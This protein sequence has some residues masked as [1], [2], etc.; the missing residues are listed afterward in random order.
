[1]SRII[2][3]IDII[4]GKCVR[5]EEGNY[6]RKKEYAANPLDMAKSYEDHGI[7]YLHLVDLDGAK[8]GQIINIQ[9]I[10]EICSQTNLI[11]D[12]GGG[13]KSDEDLKI[14]FE[15]G[16]KQVNIGSLAVKDP[17]LFTRWIEMF[18]GEKILLSADTRD[19]WVAINGWQ[20]ITDIRLADF[21]DQYL[22]KGIQTIVCTDIAK[23]GM[24]QGP[25]SD[26]Y[27]DLMKQFPKAR[28]VASGGVSSMED[29][30]SL[31]QMQVDGIIIGKAIYEGVILLTDLQ[32]LITE[33]HAN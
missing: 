17:E 16:A 23:D 21:I 7:Q 4:N 24:M 6:A 18:G 12:V 19:G 10:E 11:V 13:I 2:P 20:K 30:K 5:L 28:F 15:S 14:A 3:A 29:V 27:A 25:S 33:S 31:I 1:M 26:L 9:T 22:K 32:N 8:A